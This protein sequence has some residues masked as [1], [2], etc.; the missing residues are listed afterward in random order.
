MLL[1][2]VCILQRRDIDFETLGEFCQGGYTRVV[3]RFLGIHHVLEVFYAQFF[4]LSFYLL[5]GTTSG[6]RHDGGGG[7]VRVRL[8]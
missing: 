8:G 2:E 3:S 6:R 1:Y 4:G 5:V 7:D